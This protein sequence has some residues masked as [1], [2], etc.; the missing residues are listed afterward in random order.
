M[1]STDFYGSRFVAFSPRQEESEYP[2]VILSLD[3]VGVDLDWKRQRAVKLTED[4]FAPVH[5]DAVGEAGNF[6]P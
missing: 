3:A 6:L 1:G 4:T 2:V 5:T